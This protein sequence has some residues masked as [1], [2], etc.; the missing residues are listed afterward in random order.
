MLLQSVSKIS[1]TVYDR[2]GWSFFADADNGD[3]IAPEL[4]MVSR[5]EASAYEAAANELFDCLVEVADDLIQRKAL[6]EAGIPESLHELIYHS[7]EDDRHLHL[8]GR[9][10]F[11]GG[12]DGL[13]IRMLEFNADTPTSLPETAII[14]WALLHANNRDEKQAF[15]FVFEAL[16]EQFKT[17]ADL[18]PDFDKRILF[19]MLNDAPEDNLNVAVLEWAAREAGFE[20]KICN[21]DRVIFSKESGIFAADATGEPVYYPFWFKLVPW[22]FIAFDEPDLAGILTDIVLNGLGIILNPAYSLLLQ[23]KALLA[24]SHDKYPG[25]KEI[26]PATLT[27]PTDSSKSGYVRKVFFGRE[28]SNVALYDASGMS[29]EATGGDY[30]DQPVVYQA[31]AEL[32]KDSFG[33]YYQA[34]VFYAGQACGLGFRRANKRILDDTAHFVGHAI[35]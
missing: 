12:I 4:V 10:D 5:R 32:S 11:A 20:T 2:I 33:K 34:G 28:G 27:P 7:W 6:N 21:V 29:I 8:F 3:Y 1:R 19:S 14:Q 30:G 9:F 17:L 31:L 25:I 15:N 23:S 22:E 16:T 13:P 26:L 35:G 24:M 18:N